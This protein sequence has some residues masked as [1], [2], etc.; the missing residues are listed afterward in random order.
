MDKVIEILRRH[1]QMRLDRMNEPAKRGG[2][3]DNATA[4][5]YRKSAIE[6]VRREIE[7]LSQRGGE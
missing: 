6:D 2:L 7:A 1:E 3:R 5:L 4:C